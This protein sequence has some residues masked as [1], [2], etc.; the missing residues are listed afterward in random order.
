[1]IARKLATT[2]VNEKNAIL[3]RYLSLL[4]WAWASRRC[5]LPP[6]FRAFAG[7]RATGKLDLVLQLHLG[8]LESENVAAW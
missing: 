1:M 6:A 2:I 8:H 3:D 5:S 7:N 4:N